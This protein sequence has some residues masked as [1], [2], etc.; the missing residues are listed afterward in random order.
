MMVGY[1]TLCEVIGMV[2][3]GSFQWH[4]FSPPPPFP[5]SQLTKGRLVFKCAERPPW[6][7]V[8]WSCSA[9]LRSAFSSILSFFMNSSR[10]FGGCGSV[11]VMLGNGMD[12]ICFNDI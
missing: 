8:T 3:G 12:L 2:Q 10:H 6:F 11:G 9:R 4:F 5:G 7:G 1:V